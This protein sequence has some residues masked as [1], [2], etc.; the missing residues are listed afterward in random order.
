MRFCLAIEEVEL[1]LLGDE[2]AIQIAYP[3]YKKATLHD[4]AQRQ[5]MWNMGNIG[6]CKLCTTMMKCG[7]I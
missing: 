6:M 5:Y 2:M 4:Y 7:K 3:G 1:W